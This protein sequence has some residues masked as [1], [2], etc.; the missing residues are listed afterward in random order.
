ML[1]FFTV[2][3][4]ILSANTAFADFPRL[5]AVIA[6][7]R[8]LPRQ[9]ANRG[10]RLAFSNGIIALAVASGLLLVALRRRR[11]RARPLFAVGLFTSFTLSQAG[12]VVHHWRLREPPGGSASPSTPSAPRRPPSSSW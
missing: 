7:D 4:L 1:Q 8:F 5:S 9:L 3:I 6:A 11:H 2:A 12:M 10:D